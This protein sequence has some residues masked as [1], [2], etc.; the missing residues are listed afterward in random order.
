MTK[1]KKIPSFK[2]AADE[3]DFWHKHD[4]A[5]YIDWSKAKKVQLPNLKPSTQVISLRMP[6]GLLAAIKIE[7]HKEDVPYQ[8]LI[9]V[10]LTQGMQSLIKKSRD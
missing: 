1:L 10:L 3:A 8:S 7:A 5:E 6:E 2:K 9:K 4:S